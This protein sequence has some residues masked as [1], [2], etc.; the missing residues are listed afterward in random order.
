MC[1]FI[2]IST[3]GEVPEHKRICTTCEPDSH[4]EDFVDGNWVP[5]L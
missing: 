1:E 5:A 4:S 3:R 2:Y